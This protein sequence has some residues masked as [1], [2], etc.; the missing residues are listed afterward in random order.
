MTSR[1]M[2]YHLHTIHSMDG[3]QTVMEA[4]AEAVRLGLDEIC[5]TEH[6][7]P[8][9]PSPGIDKPPDYARWFKEIDEARRAYPGLVIKRGIEIGDNAPFRRE[10]WDGLDALP[11]DFRLLS[12]HLVNN[13]DPYEARYFQGKT[14]AEAYEEYALSRLESIQHFQDYD[15]AAH[16]GYVGKFAPYP[17]ET[18]PFAH[19]HAPEI[20][21][22]ILRCLASQGKALEINASGLRQTASPIPGADIIKR[23][24]ALG[25]EYF[26]FG[27][28]AHGAEQIYLHVAHAKKIAVSAGARWEVGFTQRKVTVYP[29]EQ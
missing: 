27:S 2:D 3:R 26:T 1:K 24:I 12:L 22:E 10:I 9:H 11:L 28:D 20:I 25:G 13:L 14:Q 5:F 29:L 21:D 8:H 23:F 15:A 17:P 6:I 4:A 7:E 18:R 19:H 16:L